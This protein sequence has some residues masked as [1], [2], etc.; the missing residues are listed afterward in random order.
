MNELLEQ[1]SKFWKIGSLETNIFLE[2]NLILQTGKRVIR[3]YY[4]L[5]GFGAVFFGTQPFTTHQ[6]PVVCY[7]PDGWFAYLTVTF[8]YLMYFLILSTVGTDG[9]FCS[10]CTSLIVQFKLLGHKFKLLET[11]IEHQKEKLMWK[12]MKQLVDY[13]NYLIRYIYTPSRR[14]RYL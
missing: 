4:C 13:H 8:W 3:Y 2:C 9:F 6:I 12:K 14:M 7:I 10:L 11:G 5:V 1:K